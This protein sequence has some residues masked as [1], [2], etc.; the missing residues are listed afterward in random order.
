METSESR[1]FRESSDIQP[2][3]QQADH[4]V[5]QAHRL[6]QEISTSI[7]KIGQ[8][9]EQI[10]IDNDDIDRAIESQNQEYHTDV[11]LDPNAIDTA[12]PDVDTAEPDAQQEQSLEFELEIEL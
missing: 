1:D 8:N 12:E 6:N 11:D 7:A 4:R 3:N 2:G 10:A 9:I 5:E